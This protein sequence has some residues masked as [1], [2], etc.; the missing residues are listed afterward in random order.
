MS[1]NSSVIYDEDAQSSDWIEIHN[2]ELTAID[3]NGY[4]LTDDPEEPDKWKFPEITLPAGG[5]LIVFASDKNRKVG[6]LHTNFRLSNESGGYLALTDPDGQTFISGFTNYPRQL[7]DISYGRTQSGGN[8]TS[9]LVREG[10]AC[11]LLVPTTDIGT[12]WQNIQFNDSA[13]EDATTGIGYERSSGYENLIGAGGD[14]EDATY[15]INSTVYIRIPFNL[16][17]INGISGLNFRMKYDD[18]FIAYLNGV[19]IASGNKPQNPV[20]NSNASQDHPDSQA[21]SF[22]DTN[23]SAQATNLLTAGNNILSIHAMNGDTT[24]SDLLALPRLEAEFISEPGEIGNPGYFQ[25]ATPGI[26]NGTDQGL[27]SGRVQFS[28]PGRG[29]T[30]SLSVN[31]L[32]PS[33]VAQIRYTTNGDVPTA[34]STLFTGNPINVSSS[35]LL[36]ARAFEPGLT[37]GPVIEEGYIRL[38]SNAQTFSSDLPVIIMERFNG[39][40]SASN[41]KAFTYFAFFEPD[42]VTGRTTLNRPYNLGT[43]GGWKVRGSSSSGFAKKAYSIEAWNEFNRNKEISPLGL[44][45]ESDW[46]LNARSVFDRSLMRNAFI[47]ELSNQIGRYAVRTR[48]VELFKDDN[49]GDLNYNNDYDGVYTFMEKISRD[50]ERVDIERL[51]QSINEEPGISGGYMMKIDRLDPGDSGLS[52][53]GRT[54]GWVYPKEDDVTSAQSNWL[55]NYINEMSAALGTPQYRDYIEVGSWIDHHLLNVLALNADALRLSTY[56]FKSRQGKIEFGPIW[57]FDRS[58][59][60]TD[61]RDNNPS[62]WAGGTN[63]FTFPWWSTLFENEN[64]WQAYIDRYFELRGG[65]FATSNIHSII[66]NMATELNEAQLRNFQRWS[67]QPRF[68]SYQGEVN[69]L[70]DWLATRLNW[71]DEQFAPRPSTNRSAGIYA[72]GTTVTLSA[73]LGANQK[74]YYTLDG[75][76]PRPTSETNTIEGTTLVGESTNVRAF[77]PGSDIGTQWRSNP[78]FDDSNWLSGR[79]GIGYERGNGYAPYINIDVDAQMQGRTSCYVRIKFNVDGEDLAGWNFMTLQSRCDDGFVAYLNGTEIVSNLAPANLNW[80]SSAI[81][82]TDDAIATTFQNFEASNFFNLLQPG[83]NLLAIH[84]LNESTTSSDF[85][86]QVKLITGFDEGAGQGGTGGI[87][88]TEPITLNETARLFARVFDSD[89]GNST[90]SGRTPVGTGWSA[91]LQVEYLVNEAP[92]SEGTLAIVEIMNNPYELGDALTEDGDFE[93]IELQNITAQ[94]IS[95]SGVSFSEGI[96]FNF[97]GKSLDPGERTLVVRNLTAFQQVHGSSRNQQIAGTYSGALENNGENLVL[98]AANGDIIQS[99]SYPGNIAPKG[100]SLLLTGDN[101]WQASRSLLGS[102]GAPEPTLSELPDI[103]VTE[104]LTNSIIPQLDVIEIHNPNAFAVDISGWLLTDDLGQP[105]KFR[106]PESTILES[107]EYITFD[108][109]E[110]TEFALDSFGEEIF[111][112]ASTPSGE[113]RDYVDGFSFGD[114]SAGVTFG[115]HIT[116]TGAV[117]YV[118]M[119]DETLGQPNSQPLAGPLI[120][121]ELMYNPVAGESEFIE[122]KNISSSTISLGGIEVSGCGFVFPPDAPDLDAGNLVLLISGNPEEFR[123]L[124]NISENVAIFGPYPGRL[125]NGGEKIR[126]KVPES[127]GVAGEPDLLVSVDI[128]DYDDILPWPTEADG[129]GFSLQ[130]LQ[131][132][133]YGGDPLSWK[134][135]AETGGSPGL[136]E[137]MDF[138]WRTLFFS[139]SEIANPSI[140]GPLADADND[141]VANVL[142]YLLATNPR[143]PSSNRPLGISSVG[144][145]GQRQLEITLTLKNQVTGFT[146]VIDSSETLEAWNLPGQQLTLWTTTENDDGTTT[147]VY[148]SDEIQNLPGTKNLFF[149]V[150]AVQTP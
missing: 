34:N 114:A 130:R 141:G 112:I 20:W 24:S 96:E 9:V 4:C 99:L 53:G 32:S 71:M 108:E 36:R 63:Y 138:D 73:P 100:H 126:I 64:F 103:L 133:E 94:K 60:S 116:S 54:L 39:G 40:P 42:P 56:F 101:V 89:G 134:P 120:V 15:D 18:G 6:E 72:P 107:D 88:Y 59:E 29:F 119:S 115:R 5:Y 146:A 83:E 90:G 19:E 135:S 144:V 44:P 128:T 105:D 11:K 113:L 25:S 76:D 68:G 49:G 48:F 65:A 143:N 82:T 136:D 81:Q 77:V 35:T 70:K 111:L 8:T 93:W 31:L 102:P 140:S 26:A 150:R 145:A 118:P 98:T 137:A 57:D 117:H 50:K 66:D 22:V 7:E 14:V 45:E 91:P 132:A 41:G 16:D 92:A 58:M 62:T 80:N 86:N 52:A 55:R 147:L 142:E 149:R 30:G 2:P 13:W 75:S 148:R 95:L 51:P 131:P 37:P 123:N 87:E 85:L 84:A 21:T 46:I 74:I 69:H 79:N 106:I 129:N 43:R 47:Y 23:L 17:S 61:N 125:D 127:S 110:F 27:P 10:D 124:H 33:P 121:S 139:A 28:Q 104:I 67:D 1:A 78:A 3:L 12:S 97:S 122:I 109:N 38:S